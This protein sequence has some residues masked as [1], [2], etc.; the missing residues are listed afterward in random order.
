MTVSVLLKAL[1]AGVSGCLDS[2]AMLF[3]GGVGSSHTVAI[4]AVFDL[5]VDADNRTL[6]HAIVLAE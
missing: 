6:N 5:A 3:C 1:V 4:T 2:W